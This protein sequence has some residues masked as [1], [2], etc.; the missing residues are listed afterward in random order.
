MQLFDSW[1]GCLSVD[2]YRRYVLPYVQQIIAGIVPG[3]PVINFAT[4]NPMLNGLLAEGGSS[5]VG[6]DWR[7]RLDDAWQV[8][9]TDRAIQGNLDPCVLLADRK[10]MRQRVQ[11]V[12]GMAG[13]TAGPHLQS[14]ARRAAA[15][16]GG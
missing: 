15:N 16:T 11:E 7:M 3:V 13:R 5:V 9:G 2:D 6:V 1:V 10:L 12:L 4:G 14:G 8:I